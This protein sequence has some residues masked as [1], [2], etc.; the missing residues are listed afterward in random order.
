MCCLLQE[1]RIALIGPLANATSRL[2]GNYAGA[3]D[4]VHSNSILLA[5]EKII[6]IGNVTYAQGLE[7]VSSTD[8]SGFQEAIAAASASDMTV[9]VVGLDTSQEDEAHDRSVLTL[10]GAQEELVNRVFTANPKTI[11]VLV[12]GGP[13]AIES[14]KDTI[15]AIIEAFYPGQLGA[16]AIAEV[17]FG[18]VN[19]SG[20]L[21]FTVYPADFI[22]RKI[23]DMSLRDNGGCT[24]QHYT[25]KALYEFGHGLSYS[26]FTYAWKNNTDNLVVH[27]TT[28]AAVENSPISYQVTVQNLG[29]IQGGDV[30]LGFIQAVDQADAPLKELFDFARVY[31]QIGESAT[32]HLS[33]PPAV[34]SLVDKNGVQSVRA[35]RYRITVGD[36]VTTV[37]LAGPDV[38]LFNLPDTKERHVSRSNKR[39]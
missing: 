38:E 8:T 35:G 37:S 21:P 39:L 11:V 33:V 20:R 2:L 12:N 27:T 3:N 29:P 36:L 14:I 18:Q 10:P 24:Y 30:V 31:L 32:V 1:M 4:L 19:P 26:V 6:G 15:P 16:N 28:A 25:G 9:V 17:L 23:S 13:L 34:L 22:K 5:I 7:N